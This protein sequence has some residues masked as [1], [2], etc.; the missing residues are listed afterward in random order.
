[1]PCC[2]LHALMCLCTCCCICSCCPCAFAP[3]YCL[4][5]CHY[6][7][8]SCLCTLLL[9]L[10][11]LLPSH[12]A[13]CCCFH[14]SCLIVT[15]IA[16]CLVVAFVLH[17]LPY[18]FKYLLPPCPLCCFIVFAPC[19][20]MPYVLVG[21]PSQISD[22]GGGVWSLDQQTSSNPTKVKK[23]SFVLRKFPLFPLCLV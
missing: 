6:L 20:F 12:L 13:P 22:V 19:C 17:A 16:S 7:C 21:I 8:T 5:A 2:C 3:C 15:F 10:H 23:N 9:P 4:C 14:T 11:L 18:H 1:M